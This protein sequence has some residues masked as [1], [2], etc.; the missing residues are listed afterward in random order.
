M[1]RSKDVVAKEKAAIEELRQSIH[2]E[3]LSIQ[4]DDSFNEDLKRLSEEKQM[5]QQ[6]AEKVRL[7][8]PQILW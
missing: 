8:F 6:Q 7:S 4:L 5:V 2:K 1:K 3:R